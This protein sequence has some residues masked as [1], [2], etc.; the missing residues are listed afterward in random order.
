MSPTPRGKIDMVK[1]NRPTEVGR[2][3]ETFDSF[4][5]SCNWECFL[6]G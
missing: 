1:K 2:V 3:D 6:K 5:C 4:V